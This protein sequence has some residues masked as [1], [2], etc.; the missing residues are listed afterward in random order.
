MY[1]V[2]FI[3]WA[4]GIWSAAKFGWLGNIIILLLLLF[5]C[6]Y[7]TANCECGVSHPNLT[8][9]GQVGGLQRVLQAVIMQRKQFCLH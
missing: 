3:C 6:V 7:E 2:L 8:R 1:S 9:T 5:F 4:L